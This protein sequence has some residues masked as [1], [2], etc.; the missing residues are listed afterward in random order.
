[1]QSSIAKI[2]WKKYCVLGLVTVRICYKRR[3]CYPVVGLSVR[4][5]TVFGDTG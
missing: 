5:K 2:V 1:M 3:E 4:R